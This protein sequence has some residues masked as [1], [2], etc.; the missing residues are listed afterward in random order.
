MTVGF[1]YTISMGK[2]SDKYICI[3]TDPL[4]YVLKRVRLPKTKIDAIRLPETIYINI[5]SKPIPQQT[6][7]NE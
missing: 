7:S 3:M 1:V 2:Y 4:G 6:E 5:F